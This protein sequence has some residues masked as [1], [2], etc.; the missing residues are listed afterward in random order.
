MGG[1]FTTGGLSATSGK[2]TTGGNVAEGGFA[3]G[4][5][6]S[7]SGGT[8][9][10]IGPCD[11]YA[12]GNTP[13]V[14]AH[15]TVR[16]LYG[17]YNGN[18][19]QVRRAS[20]KTTRDIGVLTPGGFANSAMQDAFCTGT[21]CAIS[22]IYDQSPKGNHLVVTPQGGWLT[23]GPGKEADAAA[24]KIKVN[25]HEVYGVYVTGN[26]FKYDQGVVGVG[27]RNNDAS[28]LAVGDEPEGM[29]M[30]VDGRHSNEWCCFDYGN[31]ET[32]NLDNGPGTME[33][34]YFGKSTQWGSGSGSGPWVMADLEDG[35]FSGH[36]PKIN[37]ANTPISTDYVT[38][39]LKG[40]SGWFAL[41]GGDAQSGRL[42]T[43]YDGGRPA[44]G[45]T[46]P[47]DPMRKEGAIVLGIGGDNSNTGEGTFFE[48][49][50]TFGYPSDATD[51]AVHAN[52]VAAGYGR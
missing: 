15:S 13:C 41:K 20:D 50:I 39:M 2:T 8:A 22:K 49:C 47:Y 33:A 9:T 21:P 29:Y 28:G 36:E 16:A 52:I 44:P 34:V 11:I 24:A 37:V 12:T 5:S 7:G 25:G 42:K 35:L 27:Y 23:K 38:A 40:K 30:V 6:S 32:N 4:G 1:A 17:S 51:D 26:G 19:Y 45:P 10:A 3:S 46:G 14:A 48:G 18:L 43:M 31:A